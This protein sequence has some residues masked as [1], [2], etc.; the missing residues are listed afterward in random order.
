VDAFSRTGA[1][2]VIFLNQGIKSTSR[3]NYDIA[4]ECGHL[5]MHSHLRTGSLETESQ[6]DRFASAL[7][8]PRKA[9]AREFRT[10][11]FSW[12]HVFELKRRWRVSAGAI[13]RR[14]YDLGLID[15]VAYRQAYKY[16]SFK[17]WTKG[18]PFEPDFQ[19]PE[20]LASAISALGSKVSLDL[21]GLC[22]RLRFTPNTFE[23]VT[24]VP[25]PRQKT[26]GRGDVIQF[27]AK[28]K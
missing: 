5:V 15:A 23:D 18:E 19:Q 17:R 12:D 4:H 14:A 1:T 3:W 21:P 11:R 6:A 2:S 24:G 7:L 28:S 8:L 13:I 16:M 9:F 22:E 27:P 10:S 20:L 26:N 25:V